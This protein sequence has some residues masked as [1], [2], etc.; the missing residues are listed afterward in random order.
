MRRRLRGEQSALSFAD[1]V[2]AACMAWSRLSKSETTVELV[3]L[4]AS[5]AEPT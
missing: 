4:A 2:D 1:A 3:E 5:A